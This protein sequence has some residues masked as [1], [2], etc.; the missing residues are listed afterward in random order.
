MAKS[1]K[2]SL[3]KEVLEQIFRDRDS[4]DSD[5]EVGDSESDAEAADIESGDDDNNVDDDAEK[6]THMS[7]VEPENTDDDSQAE[8]T[9]DDGASGDNDDEAGPSIVPTQAKLP[10]MDGDWTWKRCS[11]QR[12]QSPQLNV[13]KPEQV[14][15]DLPD[16]PSPYDFFK[17]Y[18]TDELLDMIVLETHR[19]A[20]QFIAYN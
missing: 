7:D 18:M 14:L 20:A 13:I 6:P 12:V 17:L 11:T 10:R 5:I 3:T 16:D 2:R 15:I 1:L 8:N 19:Y 9:G 4:D